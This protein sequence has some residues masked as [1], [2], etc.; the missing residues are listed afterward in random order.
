MLTHELMT[1]WITSDGKKYLSQ[2]EAENHEQK[3]NKE[4]L[5]WLGRLQRNLK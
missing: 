1:V 5:T 4:N 3:L 2:K